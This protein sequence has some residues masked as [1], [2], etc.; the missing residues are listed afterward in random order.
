[1]KE[2]RQQV[3][4]REA[5]VQEAEEDISHLEKRAESNL[6]KDRQY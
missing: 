4:E 5:A 6:E 2:L 1:V 3:K